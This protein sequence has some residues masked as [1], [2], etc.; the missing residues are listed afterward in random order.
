MAVNPSLPLDT[1]TMRATATRLLV[2]DAE[3]SGLN[4]V[5]LHQPC[6]TSPA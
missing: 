6:P 4:E 2:Q 3:P 1:E 5:E